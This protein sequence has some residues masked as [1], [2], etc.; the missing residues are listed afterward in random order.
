MK[1]LKA[2]P[3]DPIF[4]KLSKFRNDKNPHK[5]N[6]GIGIYADK[7]GNPYVMPTVQKATKHI[8]TSN[9][10]YTSMQGDKEFL[11]LAQNFA[12][13]KTNTYI[14]QV[15]TAGGTQACKIYGDIAKKLE[16][17]TYIIPKPAWTS[18]PDLLAHKK[19]IQFPHLNKDK[20][21][22]FK[23]Y[24]S[25][26]KNLKKPQETVLL[27][28]GGQAHNQTGKNLSQNQLEKLIPLINEKE[29]SVLIDAAYLGLGAKLET[30]LK[31]IREAFNKIKNSALAI[32]FSKNACMYR[33]RLG[34][35]FIKTKS[36]K[37]KKIVESH[38]QVQIR[39]SISNPPA[40]GAMVMTKI[41]KD[42]Q[43]EWEEELK[44]MKSVIDS[45]REF[46]ISAMNPKLDSFKECRGMF[47]ILDINKNQIEELE[48]K[49]S[50]YILDSGRINFAGITDSNK[51]YLAESL[52]KVL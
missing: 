16:I 1:K 46:L 3:L 10:N 26:I 49:Y 37:E 12:L 4:I 6:L 47:A 44:Q 50:I 36:E 7:K 48:K 20:E 28:Q 32:S 18:Y 34:A 22:N 23:K 51:N 40:F 13:G 11:D 38:F 35:L 31:F 14:A 41:L 30:D 45:K 29:I 33:H 21:V 2:L 27:L 52:K 42:S 9:F 8:D 17:D 25:T 24:I 43:D 19:L 39:Q 15:Q 5:I